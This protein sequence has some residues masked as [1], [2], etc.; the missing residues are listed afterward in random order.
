M[1]S[2]NWKWNVTTLFQCIFLA[3]WHTSPSRQ[4][5]S[6]DPFAGISPVPGGDL[7]IIK[8]VPAD[9]LFVYSATDDSGSGVLAY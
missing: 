5:A 1:Y 8:S 9:Q 6:F 2:R 4:Q 7:N 3:E